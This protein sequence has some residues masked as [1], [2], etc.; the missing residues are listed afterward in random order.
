MK[1]SLGV[2]KRESFDNG[3]GDGNGG[4]G[5]KTRGFL[6]SSVVAS[7]GFNHLKSNMFNCTE[8]KAPQEGA[9]AVWL[10]SEFEFEFE[11]RLRWSPR[12]QTSIA[13]G[14]HGASLEGELEGASELRMTREP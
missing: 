14:D 12:S 5:G 6:E 2:M 3:D 13:T 11:A 8:G 7:P 10:G 1:K 9:I 4:G